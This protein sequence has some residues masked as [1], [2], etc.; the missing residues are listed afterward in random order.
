M[1]AEF[2]NEVIMYR[3]SKKPEHC[4]WIA[5]VSLPWRCFPAHLFL[6]GEGERKGTTD[7]CAAKNDCA[8]QK[9]SFL[10]PSYLERHVC[11]GP[12]RTP[13]SLP[14]CSA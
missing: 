14:P 8:L 6:E 11:S 3:Q 2:M 12:F 5:Q 9:E 10:S 7:E 13:F 1:K 4:Q